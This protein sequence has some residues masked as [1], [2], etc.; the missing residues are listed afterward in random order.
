MIN[1]HIKITLFLLAIVFILIMVG[2]FVP[3]VGTKLFEVAGP[4]LVFSE[5]IAFLL[6]GATLIVLTLKNKIERPLKKLLLL[7]GISAVGFF[8]FV[9]LH[10]FTS[11]LLSMIYKKEIE[12][13][14]FFLLAVFVCPLG[15]LV[16]AVGSVV[17][18]LRKKQDKRS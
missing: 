2:M 9:L 15:F 5:Q 18:L 7:T 8:V 14:V 6:L 13:L 4:V 16:G 17:L 11:G 12:E 1:L 10:N 3:Y